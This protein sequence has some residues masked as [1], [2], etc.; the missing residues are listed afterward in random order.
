M[1]QDL[2][3]LRSPSEPQVLSSDQSRAQLQRT[4]EHCRVHGRGSIQENSLDLVTD[5][6][7]FFCFIYRIRIQR[8]AVCCE[9]RVCSLQLQALLLP[10]RSR[11]SSASLALAASR[12]LYSCRLLLRPPSS[13]AGR[14]RA[15][16]IR[17]SGRACLLL[18]PGILPPPRGSTLQ[19]RLTRGT[20]F[21]SDHKCVLHLA[22][23]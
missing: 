16:V 14:R 21:F 10:L 23:S 22:L 8:V 11:S 13:P 12:R 18:P 7:L 15:S 1:A 9:L 2:P 20:R 5:L 19:S 3:V 17:R 4:E 6:R